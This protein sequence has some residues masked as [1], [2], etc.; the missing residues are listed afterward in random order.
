M[1]RAERAIILAAGKGIRLRPITNGIPKPLVTV[2]G[3]RMID[4]IIDG[5]HKN[6]NK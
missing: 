4:T 1:Y 2:N 6:R 5:L 3:I